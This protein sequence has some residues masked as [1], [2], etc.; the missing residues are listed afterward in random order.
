MEELPHVNNQLFMYQHFAFNLRFEIL[1]L[2]TIKLLLFVMSLLEEPA[3]SLFR[4]ECE[5]CIFL[6]DITIYQAT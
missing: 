4:V 2:T 5:G 6:S 1:V 3:V